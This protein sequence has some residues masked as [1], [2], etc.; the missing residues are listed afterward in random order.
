MEYF[1]KHLKDYWFIIVFLG[2]V[3]VSWTTFTS[4]L[5]AVESRLTR[6]EDSFGALEL[7]RIDIAVIKNDISS[8]KRTINE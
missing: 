7:V 5:D 1:A 2:M 3:V 6:L 8:I 4:R